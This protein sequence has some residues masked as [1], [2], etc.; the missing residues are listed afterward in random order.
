MRR[1]ECW[2]T[3]C[4][5][6]KSA[7]MS[8]AAGLLTTFHFMQ[9]KYCELQLSILPCIR[10]NSY[11]RCS[12]FC[13]RFFRRRRCFL[14]VF[15]VQVSS[16]IFVTYL[17]IDV[18]YVRTPSQPRIHTHSHTFARVN[19]EWGVR[20]KQT[21][22]GYKFARTRRFNCLLVS[23][24][25]TYK[26]TKLQPNFVAFIG[27]IKQLI[28]ICGQ[29][30][31]VIQDKWVCVCARPVNISHIQLAWN[32]LLFLSSCTHNTQHTTST[33]TLTLIHF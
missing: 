10:S 30:T 5:K 33:D 3:F 9:R 11:F 32:F 19:R 27:I 8:N 31:S 29:S 1:N 13:F 12:I 4:S 22:F 16:Q 24:V 21:H 7:T 6:L 28:G 17:V 23:C 18:F 14:I 2:R 15:I 25:L 20:D 26:F